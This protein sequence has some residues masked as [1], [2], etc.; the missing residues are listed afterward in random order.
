M[1]SGDGSLI[2]LSIA[3]QHHPSRIHLLTNFSNLGSDYEVVED[4]DPR[5]RHR[6]AWRTYRACLERTPPDC[7]HRLVL[8]DDAETCPGFLTAALSAIAARP[9]R[10]LA[11][12]VPNTLRRG[13]RLLMEACQRD[14]AFCELFLNEWVPVVALCWPRGIVDEF[15]A[16]ANRHGYTEAHHRADDAIVGTFCRERGVATVATVP[17]LVEH[18]DDEPSL[19]GNSTR[20]RRARCYV[21]DGAHLI[22]WS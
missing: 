4:P 22:N 5:G 10:M 9:D 17:S 14:E 20:I 13:S 7:T 3:I 19:T 18:P 8:Q 2:K 12:F 11:F 16:W 21:G 1:R 15:I 6:S